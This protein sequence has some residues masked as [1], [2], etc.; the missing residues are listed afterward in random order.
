MFLQEGHKPFLQEHHSNGDYI[1]WFDLE[2]CHFA[3]PTTILFDELEIPFFAKAENPPSV[4]STC[5]R[6]LVLAEGQG[7]PRQLGS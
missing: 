6:F 1:F 7:I 2:S 4:A 5:K 3:C